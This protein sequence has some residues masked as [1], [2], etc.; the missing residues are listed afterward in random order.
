MDPYIG[1]IRMVGFNFAPYGWAFCS[2]QIIPIQQNTAL[3]ALI[4]NYYG[5]NGTTNFALPNLQGRVPMGAGTG[6]GLTPRNLASA[7]GAETVTLNQTQMPY[8]NHAM[9][10]ASSS[11]VNLPNGAAPGDMPPRGTTTAYAAGG[12]VSMAA[13]MLEATGG[14]QPHNNMMPFQVQNFVIAMMGIFPT[15]P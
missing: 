6:P 4:G 12:Q 13:G 8:H 7:G 3:F 15:R 5:G 11:G 10:S 9:Q 2:G 14:N 1:E